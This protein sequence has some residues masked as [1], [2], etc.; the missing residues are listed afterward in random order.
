MNDI[1]G[2]AAKPRAE[3]GG[4]V[5]VT[6]LLPRRE[7]RLLGQILTVAAIAGGAV[8]ERADQS[9]VTSYDSAKGLT[10]SC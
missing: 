7:K 3:P 9:L 5:Q 2:D 4:F 10:V 6:Q 1:A 8:S